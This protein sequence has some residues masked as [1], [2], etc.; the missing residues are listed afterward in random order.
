MPFERKIENCPISKLESTNICPCSRAFK[1]RFPLSSPYPCMIW[2]VC[3]ALQTCM[4]AS[5]FAILNGQIQNKRGWVFFNSMWHNQNQGSYLERVKRGI[6]VWNVW[7]QVHLQLVC[8]ITTRN[9]FVCAGGRI[10]KQHILLRTE[11]MSAALH[12]SYVWIF[13]A[14][15]KIDEEARV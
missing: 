5:Q 4:F 3:F 1:T 15:G 8:N 9:E 2:F 12:F 14:R 7:L 6:L 11:I 10:D 13:D